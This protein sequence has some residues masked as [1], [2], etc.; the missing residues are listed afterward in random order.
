MKKKDFAVPTFIVMLGALLGYLWLAPSGHPP[1]PQASFTDLQ[2]QHFSLEQLRGKPLIINFWATTC[3]GCVLEIPALVTLSKKYSAQDL[4]IIGVAMDYDPE[5]QVREM[6]RQKHMT[7]PVVL[8]S[9]GDLARVF[10][11]VSLIPTTFF[12][13]RE[14]GIYKHKLGEMTH[15]ELETTIQSLIF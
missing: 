6:V 14:G 3:P 7:Y 9:K 12:I 8:D 11:N 13:T 10:G 1:A 15:A 4:V 5:S 2:G